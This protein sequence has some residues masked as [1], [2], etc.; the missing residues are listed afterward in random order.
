MWRFLVGGVAFEGLRT[1]NI[2]V[3]KLNNFLILQIVCKLLNNI[4]CNGAPQTLFAVLCVALCILLVQ[5]TQK[6]FYYLSC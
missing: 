2:F 1:E 3:I 5:R 4:V 6:F